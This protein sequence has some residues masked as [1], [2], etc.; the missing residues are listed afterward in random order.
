MRSQY[1][2]E[3]SDDY[4]VDIPR[5]RGTAFGGRSGRIILLGD[6]SEVLTD[7]TDDAEMFDHSMD[8]DKDVENQIKKGSPG[9]SDAESTRTERE[10]TPGPPSIEEQHEKHENVSHGPGTTI[11]GVADTPDSKS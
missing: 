4:D 5:S 1:N 7:S 8:D 11:K 10:D 9:A 2:H 6:G 3:D